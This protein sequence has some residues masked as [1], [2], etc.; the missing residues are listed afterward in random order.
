MDI[1]L[2]GYWRSSASYRVRI[3]LHLKQLNFIYT[4]VHLVRQDG[5]QHLAQYKVLNPAELVPVLID[6]DGTVLNQSLAIIEYLEEQYPDSLRLLPESVSAKAKVRALALDIACDIQPLANLRVLQH[7]QQQGK[8]DKA[9]QNHWAAHWMQRG[10]IAFEEQLSKTAG[11][12]C[13][14]DTVTMADLCLVPQ[15]YNALRFSLDLD[16]YPLIQHVYHNCQQLAGFVAARP[17][18]QSDAE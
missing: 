3:A 12:Y 10:F 18:N 15:V 11:N 2:F 5:E 6:Q 1:K 9:Q 7:L 14:G 8:F 17:E 16:D 4:P 13:F